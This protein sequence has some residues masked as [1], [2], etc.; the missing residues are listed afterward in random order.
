MCIGK[1]VNAL[2][3]LIL[4]FDVLYGTK[5][6][7]IGW[8]EEGDDKKHS[9]EDGFEESWYLKIE[10]KL[11]FERNQILSCVIFDD[12]TEKKKANRWK[13]N[14]RWWFLFIFG[15]MTMLVCVR[16]MAKVKDFWVP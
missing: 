9:K 2:V 12:C 5:N 1:D 15:P 8:C 14:E 7:Y 6:I 3:I 16:F 10:V 13:D 11:L 4:M